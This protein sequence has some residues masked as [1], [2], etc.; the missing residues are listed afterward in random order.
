MVL[1]MS[2]IKWIMYS[3]D[4]EDDHRFSSLNGLVTSSGE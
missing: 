1:A 2:Q 4:E 3:E